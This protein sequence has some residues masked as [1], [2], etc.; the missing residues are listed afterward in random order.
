MGKKYNHYEAIIIENIKNVYNGWIVILSLAF[1]ISI[2]TSFYS[3][4]S[5]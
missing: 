1:Y 4:P 2:Y 5:M 3:L